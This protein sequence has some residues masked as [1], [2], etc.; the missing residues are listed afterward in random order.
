MPRA[1]LD[2]FLEFGSLYGGMNVSNCTTTTGAGSAADNNGKVI[3][4][5]PG[6]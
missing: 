4:T 3:I 2:A 6:N 1:M 5:W